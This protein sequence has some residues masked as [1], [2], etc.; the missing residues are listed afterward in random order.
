MDLG[1]DQ[2]RNPLTTDQNVLQCLSAINLTKLWKI[3]KRDEAA[4]EDA[5]G[6]CLIN[7]RYDDWN[8]HSGSVLQT[9]LDRLRANGTITAS[10]YGRRRRL[11]LS[12]KTLNLR[13]KECSRGDQ[14]EQYTCPYVHL[15]KHWHHK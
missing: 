15:D 8:R 6:F 3:L 11:V 1:Y 12:G 2:R 14:C 7:G 4:A 10:E 9:W 5:V 13:A